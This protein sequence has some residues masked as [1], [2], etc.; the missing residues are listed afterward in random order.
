MFS[1]DWR[2]VI[3]VTNEEEGGPFERQ[4]ST[5]DR[6]VLPSRVEEMWVPKHLHLLSLTFFARWNLRVVTNMYTNVSFKLGT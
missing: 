4:A 3:D 1:R 2:S 6:I 5:A